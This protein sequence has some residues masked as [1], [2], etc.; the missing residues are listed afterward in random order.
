MVTE[1]KWQGS[2]LIELKNDKISLTLISYG[3]RMNEIHY[4]GKDVTIGYDSMEG[5]RRSQVYTNAVV[6]RFANR[7]A[8][9]R[10]TLN[11]KE[12]A[13]DINENGVT[14]LHGGSKGFDSLEWDYEIVDETSVRFFRFSPHMEMGYPGNLTLSVTYTL[15]DDGVELLY[16]AICDRDTILNLTNHAYFNLDGYDGE[17][18][19]K[20]QMQLNADRYLPVDDLL[21]PVGDPVSVEGTKFDFRTMRYVA[22]DFDHSFVFGDQREYKKLGDLYSPA[23]GIGLSIYSDMPALQV[24]TCGRMNEKAGKGGIPLHTHQAIALETQFFPDSPNHPSYPSTVLKGG[25]TF[26]SVTKY[27]FWK[28]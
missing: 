10:F 6:G 8:G 5:I 12:Y 20:M 1:K 13:L 4:E 16:Q 27:A 22:D 25:K 26:L 18:C 23:S 15:E 2:H 21:I 3:A 11:G 9:G 14:H 24:Y 17:D 28:K 7:I 19:L